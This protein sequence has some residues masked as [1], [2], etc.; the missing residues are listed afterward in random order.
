M[1]GLLRPGATLRIPRRLPTGNL[2]I[3]WS[4]PLTRGLIGCF[5]P[6]VMGG[7][8]LTAQCPP[9]AIKTATDTRKVNQEGPCWTSTADSAGLFGAS[10]PAA[11]TTWTQFSLYWRGFFTSYATGNSKIFGVE[12]NNIGSSPFVVASMGFGGN[13]V[14]FVV[15]WNT[16]GTYTANVGTTLTAGF[17]SLGATFKVGGNVVAYRNGLVLNTTAFGA[18]AP[19]NAASS[20]INFQTSNGNTGNLSASGNV[21]YVWNRELSAAEVTQLDLDP[22][23]FLVADEPEMQALQPPKLFTPSNPC[24]PLVLKQPNLSPALPFVYNPATSTFFTTTGAQTFTVPAGVTQIIAECYGA[25]G[26]GGAGGSGGGNGAGGGAY[27]QQVLT[28]VPGSTVWINVGLGGTGGAILNGSGTAGGDTWL[29]IASNAIPTLTS[30]GA[31]AKGGGLGA[32]NGGTAGAGGAAASGVGT[33]KNSGGAGGTN[34][35]SDGG[36]AGGGCAG[37]SGVGGAGGTN[38]PVAG[39]NA[40]GGGGGANNAAGVGANGASA[41]Q[42]GGAGGAGRGGG[43]GTGGTSPGGTGGNATANSGG[44][45]GGG[46]GQTTGALVCGAGGNGALDSS[47]YGTGNPGPGGGGGSGGGLTSGSTGGTVGAGGTSVGYGAGG[48]SA[49]GTGTNGTNFPGGA[50]TSGFVAITYTLVQVATSFSDVAD[51]PVEPFV[52][53]PP[54]LSPAQ[55]FA[56]PSTT[57][58]VSPESPLPALS[59]N[60]PNLSLAQPFAIR[61]ENP[62]STAQWWDQPP[63]LQRHP[64]HLDTNQPDWYNETQ[65]EPSIWWWTEPVDLER[66]PAHLDTNLPVVSYRDKDTPSTLSFWFEPI[67]LERHPHQTD[68]NQPRVSYQDQATP[69]TWWWSQPTALQ[70]HPPQLD[71]NE[72]RLVAQQFAEPAVWW[73]TESPDLQ[74]HPTHLDTN[75]SRLVNPGGWTPTAFWLLPQIDVQKHPVELFANQPFVTFPVVLG[76]TPLAFGF[77]AQPL[78]LH[79]H[80][81]HLDTNQQRLVY[82][83][84]WTPDSFGF[85]IE[86]GNLQRHAAHLD[87]NQSFIFL[88]PIPGSTPGILGFWAQPPDLLRHATFLDTN[89]PRVSYQDLATPS[90]FGFW[91]RPPDLLRHPSTLDTNESRL[92]SQQFA[93]PGIWW[94]GQPQ[95]QPPRPADLW[96]GQPYVGQGWQLTSTGLIIPPPALMRPSAPSLALTVPFVPGSLAAV[97]PNSLALFDQPYL[98]NHPRGL[99]TWQY[100]VGAIIVPPNATPSNASYFGQ[101]QDLLRRPPAYSVLPWTYIPGF[102]FPFFGSAF[103]IARTRL[104]QP[105]T[106]PRL[107]VSA[108]RISSLRA[109]NTIMQGFNKM[110]RAPDLSPPIVAGVEQEYVT[111]DFAKG[112]NPGIIISAIVAVNVYSLTGNDPTPMVRI[113][114]TPSLTASPSSLLANQGVVGLFGNMIAGLYLLQAII[115]TSDGQVL[116]TE[117]RWPC[118]SA[119]P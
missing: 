105:A 24:Q 90:G 11:F 61:I 33:I 58:P 95:F 34:V 56:I 50:G 7:V 23:A 82:P 104:S 31:L 109:S 102:K 18:T 114:N 64:P 4:H 9:L 12:F 110:S 119:T 52:L 116:S 111:F 85:W 40:G 57:L 74:F 75:Q 68:P 83:V 46:G 86:P 78:D 44:G 97:T 53:Q 8:N 54:N 101:P 5:V 48:G 17:Q 30:Q 87:T 21:G 107:N 15:E 79:R 38:G 73:Y 6:G 36:G 59:L 25:G 66:H 103:S 27:S 100:R 14:P 115:Q 16:N 26:G 72:S 1:A 117:A 108:R 55:P 65:N 94:Y 118:V 81:P 89:V 98:S 92:V 43:S 84:G 35:S 49:G 13:N 113:L 39:F 91:I 51:N 32:G 88:P 20:L 60:W 77:W 96:A 41:T 99:F 42:A 76:L 22:Y 37:P 93:E 69:A 19:T 63:D 112:L 10:A 70:W 45:G 71:T 47:V 3:D 28:V 62:T 2:S 80:P 67:D 106:K 29:N